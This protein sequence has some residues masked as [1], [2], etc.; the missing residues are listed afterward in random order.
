MLPDEDPVVILNGDVWHIAEDGRRAR[1]SFCGQPLR[2]RRA[3]ARLKTIGAQNACPACLRL[4]REVHQAR[5][6]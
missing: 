3:H 5:G 1:V 6:H 4:F 2:D